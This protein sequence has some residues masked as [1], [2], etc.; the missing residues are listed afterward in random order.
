MGAGLAHAFGLVADFAVAVAVKVSRYFHFHS[1][2][3]MHMHTHAIGRRNCKHAGGEAGTVR[4]FGWGQRQ[5]TIVGDHPCDVRG[6][7]IISS[8]DTGRGGRPFCA[9]PPHFLFSFVLSS[10]FGL[11]VFAFFLPAW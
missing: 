9:G 10:P 4:S 2:C 1:S 7:K 5:F 6:N 11:F 3:A 8:R